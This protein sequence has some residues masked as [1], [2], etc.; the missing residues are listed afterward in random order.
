MGGFNIQA[1][2]AWTV[3]Y[4]FWNIYIL[5][6]INPK[7]E[8]M[9]LVHLAISIIWLSSSVWRG[10]KLSE[11]RR[12]GCKLTHTHS[13]CSAPVLLQIH[14]FLEGFA[15]NMAEPAINAPAPDDIADLFQLWRWWQLQPHSWKLLLQ[16]HVANIC[17]YDDCC[18]TTFS[19][20]N[21]PP[22]FAAFTQLSQINSAENVNMNLRT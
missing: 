18:Q 13:S 21:T 9:A 8:Q 17:S 22:A 15:E 5:T 14:L 20:R 4:Y 16:C 12:W 3:S 1:S 2:V 11:S 10:V 6:L 7:Q 19:S